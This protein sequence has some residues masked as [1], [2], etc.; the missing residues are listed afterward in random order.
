MAVIYSFNL[1][2][3]F[4]LGN[5]RQNVEL[6]KDDSWQPR[7]VVKTHLLLGKNSQER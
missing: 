1:H 6:Q 4:K 3:G 5:R 7:E 2:I